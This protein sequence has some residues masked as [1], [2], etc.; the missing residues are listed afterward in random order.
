M[1]FQELRT[2]YLDMDYQDFTNKILD[3]LQDGLKNTVSNEVQTLADHK[4]YLCLL[5]SFRSSISAN[6]RRHGTNFMKQITSMLST[7]ED[8]VYDNSLR[9]IFE[10]I[11][12]VDDCDFIDSSDCALDIK[13]SENRGQ[14]ILTYNETGFAPINVF[15]VTG[16]AEAAKNV[17]DGKVQIGEKGIGFKSV[18]G[19][20]HRVW[21]QS[22]KFSFELDRSDFCVPI[23][24]YD[25]RYEETPG[26]RLTL[27][28]EPTL[29]KK[30]YEK[31][32]Q[33]YGRPNSVFQN[34]PILFL[35]KLTHLHFFTDE[36]DSLTF[37]VSKRSI[38]S[39]NEGLFEEDTVIGAELV[40]RKGYNLNNSIR[41]VRYTM[42]IVFDRNQCIS[43]YGS[44]TEL[45]TRMLKMQIIFPNSDELPKLTKLTKHTKQGAF[46]SY[47]PTGVHLS[48]PLVCHV[49]FKLDASRE[50][51][52][53]Q[54]E[55]LWFLHC[56]HSFS[57]FLA[58]A[59]INY[60][61]RYGNQIA[62][63]VPAK[64]EAFFCQDNE[65]AYCLDRPELS[66]EAFSQQKLFPSIQ[67]ELHAADELCFFDSKEPVSEPILVGSLLNTTREIFKYPE[68]LAK[69]FG[70]EKIA[71]IPEQLFLNAFRLNASTSQI[72][73]YLEKYHLLESNMWQT[74]ASEISGARIS[75]SQIRAIFQHEN[76]LK[77][78][79]RKST[80]QKN[81]IFPSGVLV[82]YPLSDAKDVLSIDPSG[83]KF[84]LENFPT[85]LQQY[86]ENIQYR[87]IV[88]D[89][90]STDFFIADNVLILSGDI[91]EAL[92][93]LCGSVQKQSLFGLQLKYRQVSRTLNNADNTFS[94][95]DFLE[96]LRNL[97]D[98]Q[99]V[100]LGKE[101]YTNYINLLEQAGTDS[102]ERFLNEILQNA[103]DCIYSDEVVP[104]FNLEIKGNTVTAQ[105][106]E[107]GFSKSNVRAITA[108]GESTKKQLV[109]D[110]SIG[111]KGVG[112]KS[113]F[114][115]ASKV[116]VHSGEFHFS[117]TKDKPTIP[118]IIPPINTE[119]TTGTTMILHL[120]NS[121]SSQI[122]T[123]DNILHLCRCLRKLKEI[124]IGKVHIRIQDTA[125]HRV[126][127]VNEKKYTYRVI[128]YPFRV[129]DVNLIA[130]R[131][132]H[133]R[134]ID[135]EQSITFYLPS[136]KI[137]GYIYCGLPTTVQLNVPLYI[138]APFE[139]TTSRDDI[140][141]TNWNTMVWEQL[142][143]GYRQMLETAASSEK[144]QALQYLGL[145]WSPNGKTETTS[146][147]LFQK[148]DYNR[149]LHDFVQFFS[150][151]KIIPTFSSEHQLVSAKE[152]VVLY[153]LEAYDFIATSRYLK[154]SLYQIVD[155]NR[156][157]KYDSKLKALGCKEVSIGESVQFL[158]S[159]AASQV[160]SAFFSKFW[161]YLYEKKQQLTEGLREKIKSVAVTP[162]LG[163]TEGETDYVRFTEKEIFT[164][165]L[166]AISPSQYYI[167]DTKIAAKE[168]VEG[169]LNVTINQMDDRYRESLFK[170]NLKSHLE[171]DSATVLYA[172]LL[173]EYRKSSNFK[174][175]GE[176]IVTSN[177][178]RKMIPLKNELGEIRIGQIYYCDKEKD[179]FIGSVIP[180]C[181]CAQECNRFAEFAGFK[182]L[183]DVDFEDL[184]IT[185]PLTADD[186]ESLQDDYF[187]YGAMILEACIE[188]QL[189]PEDLIHDYHLDGLQKQEYAIELDEFPNEP[190]NNL[191]RL[192]DTINKAPLQRIVK[193]ERTRIVDCIQQEDGT[194]ELFDKSYARSQILR[195]YTSLGKNYCICQMCLKGKP[196]NLIEVNNIRSRPQY[197]WPEMRLSLCLE[198]SK[199]FES[200]RSNPNLSA[201]FEQAIPSANTFTSG[202]V[203]VPI[204]T[205]AITFTQTHLE[206]IKTILKKK[207]C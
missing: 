104:Q 27:F 153:P 1:N 204:G 189:I 177:T 21:I 205:V 170:E 59:Y 47:L 182:E 66:G 80:D 5:N 131:E 73:C 55:N 98:S 190:V 125:T 6:D 116:E 109:G 82:Q 148:E 58:K 124:K 33:M 135:R 24:V 187:K 60:A 112:F 195:R 13:F 3:N 176:E 20:A 180:S 169:V 45:T 39:E 31:I 140:R 75:V 147:K 62:Y 50:H 49:P 193:E 178:Y 79:Q 88:L 201:Q 35:N 142:F 110:K 25:E 95:K 99:R 2:A 40:S 118:K 123:P 167:L 146:F 22:G 150:S 52:D 37:S 67:G 136:K 145:E 203:K 84:D 194:T 74:L 129:E 42:P 185:K 197:Y 87:C 7:G 137:N 174:R 117:L 69:D 65:K 101:Q 160:E 46:Y 23:P 191:K 144:I 161:Q 10:L 83:E 111:E 51:I 108:I 43:R 172:Y 106:N 115:V 34:N 85:S 200:L 157:V 163:D 63:Y 164:D 133:Q 89:L 165:P 183:C 192:Q 198:C 128:R 119:A 151:C 12:N 102:A 186:I 28:V 171:N 61:S 32:A 206:Q 168:T 134:I 156:T 18:F 57:D 11:Q 184:K 15:A 162:V 76:C 175:L 103:D 14:I 78:F 96:L 126:I 141:T 68:G 97:R 173:K 16:I 166:A 92:S 8:G 77:A 94:N 44:E 26:T 132:N 56:C 120:S 30:T 36:F 138:D 159:H 41:C 139:L 202:P 152:N 19:V 179:Y 81:H 196:D 158:L 199:Q 4:D 100:A 93:D 181:R 90:G 72:F 155:T 154:R 70:M 107:Q 207:R 9:Y 91:L 143:L 113:V 130:E 122:Q 71:D 17:Q 105:Y 53:S 121:L 149:K 114:S 29:V 38:S 86:F 64:R 54:N 48:V 188:K 127:F